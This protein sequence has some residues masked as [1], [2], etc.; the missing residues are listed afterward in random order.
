MTNHQYSIALTVTY[1][2][3]IIVEFPSNLLLKVCTLLA[4]AFGLPDIA[5]IACQGTYYASDNGCMLGSS[6]RSPRSATNS[7]TVVHFLIIICARICKV[8]LGLAGLPF[9]PWPM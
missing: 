1:V 9:L 7:S 5:F 3:Y 6:Y 8:L 2:P 4:L